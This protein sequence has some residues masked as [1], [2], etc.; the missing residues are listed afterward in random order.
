MGSDH[1]DHKGASGQLSS[2]KTG[3]AADNKPIPRATYRLQFN[4]EFGFDQAAAL[5]PYLVDLGVSHVYCSPYLKAR[6]GSAHGY[7]IIS[8][9]DLNP[10][11]GDRGSFDRMVEAFRRNGL[12][13]VLDF[14]PN[15]MGVGGA[16]NPWWLD[17]LEWGR[18]SAFAGWFDINWE[19]DQRYLSGKLL[20]PVLGE[21]YGTALGSGA[22]KLK[23]DPEAGAF[24]VWAYER[25]K[26]PIY[27]PHYGRI[28]R[29]GHPELERLGDVFSHLLVRDLHVASRAKDGRAALAAKVQASP[30]VAG[31]LAEAVDRFN[32]VPGDLESWG[33]LDKLI[34]DQHWRVAH[35]RVAGDDINYRRFFDVNELACIRMEL[36]ELFE[37][38]HA[39]IFRLL[40]DGVLD[41]LRIDHIDGL[42]DPKQ[43]CLQLREKAPRPLYLV[44]E[45]ILARH[46]EIREDWDVD[47]T[48][49]YEVAS[50]I[51]GLLLDPSGED[52]LTRFYGEFTGNREDFGDIVRR[53]K[54]RIMENELAGDL[55]SLAHDAAGIA[56]SNPKTADFTQNVLHRALKEIIA[57]FPVYR[58]YIDDEAT[59]TAADRR[60]CDW[61]LAKARR[62]DSAIDASVFDFLHGLLTCGLIAG[63][64]S[65]FS[66]V[67]VI[68]LAMRIQQY[69]GPVMAK[70]LEDTAF[71]QYNRM[72][73]LNEVGG[74]PAEPHVSISSF[75]HA[76][77]RR[78]HRFPHSMLSTSTHDSKRGEDVRARLLVLSERPDEWARCVTQWSRILR[79]GN[80]GSP[81]ELPPDRNDEYAFYQMLLGSWPPEIAI[82]NADPVQ[83]DTFRL[84]LERATTKAMREAK[85]H[86][87][88]SA[89]NAAYE[90]AVLAFIRSALDTTRKN[91]FLDSFAEFQAEIATAGMLNSLI[92]T[93]LKLT[94]PGVPDLY[95]GS[96]LWDLNFVDPDNRRPV[97]FERR[98][99]LLRGIH[100]D[101]GRRL[102]DY[103]KAR[104]SDWSDGGVKLRVAL[105]L[106]QLRKRQSLLFQDGSYEPL[107]VSGR[108]ADRICAFARRTRNAIVIVAILPHPGRNALDDVATTTVALPSGTSTR[109]WIDLFSQCEII[110]QDDSIAAADLFALAPFA[111]LSPQEKRA[112]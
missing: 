33:E 45:K 27:P 100:R 95:Q 71:Y 107:S 34:R 79:A 75:H 66:R 55:N 81:E 20:V 22:L 25:H 14:V 86:T 97:D 67:S 7:D 82:N 15:H 112:S 60:D 16:D 110:M 91:A 26:L 99:Q 83:M 36:P 104:P 56:R 90:D 31:A 23:F 5:A 47:G 39:L 52:R 46:E 84:R 111:V 18:D 103:F 92:Q 109:I 87:T 63:S 108:A 12:G 29:D 51:S 8:H 37:H 58:T 80:A 13:Q 50:L 65:G 42:R 21:Q 93:V 35:F 94:L 28:L 40:D 68:R 30:E 102:S 73:A 48:T 88:W 96:E 89:P 76:N 70:G 74:H 3:T 10:D 49:G 9:T 77:Q 19:P 105:E 54:I 24:S 78:A 11:L 6:P 32:G 53:C 69:S 2:V 17:V 41:G 57:V 43:Y 1:R 98:K 72:L 106:L 61:A 59:P 64:K 38:A 101:S 62:Q 85:I 44:V 4:S